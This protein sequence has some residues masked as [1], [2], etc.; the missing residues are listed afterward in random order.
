MGSKEYAHL[1][2]IVFEGGNNWRDL[3][4]CGEMQWLSL[5]STKL[6]I[7]SSTIFFKTTNAYQCSDSLAAR[8]AAQWKVEYPDLGRNCSRALMIHSADW[9]EEM[10]NLISGRCTRE[11]FQKAGS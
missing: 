5:L 2:D 1:A 4:L 11:I 3:L 6:V 8:F 9:T 10:Y 7:F